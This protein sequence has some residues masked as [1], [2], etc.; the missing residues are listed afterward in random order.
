MTEVDK[1]LKH[2][3]D[4]DMSILGVTTAFELGLSDHKPSAE[5]I[6]KELNRSIKWLSD[7]INNLTSRLE[8]VIFGK[9]DTIRCT[10]NRTGLLEEGSWGPIPMTRE[11]RFEI[12]KLKN[13]VALLEEAVDVIRSLR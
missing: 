11:E 3:A 1:L 7:P 4:N 5:D 2:C 12:N 6:A 8:G 13:E 10:E 9:K